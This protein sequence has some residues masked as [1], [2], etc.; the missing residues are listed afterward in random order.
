MQG[1]EMSVVPEEDES[2][3]NSPKNPQK[4]Q[5]MFKPIQKRSNA[6]EQTKSHTTFGQH[7]RINKSEIK[8]SNVTDIS[9]N[10]SQMIKIS[11]SFDGFCQ[12]KDPNLTKTEILPDKN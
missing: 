5:F 4:I 2:N 6:S 11:N 10:Q 1:G 12:D 7:E 8:N 3:C 9:H